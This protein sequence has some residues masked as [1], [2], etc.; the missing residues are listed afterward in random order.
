MD[1][2]LNHCRELSKKVETN[3]S[4]ASELLKQCESLQQE[5]KAMRQYRSAIKDLNSDE[6][7][8][9]RLPHIEFSYIKQLQRDNS[10][11]RMLLEEHQ[12]A[13]EM[14]MQKYRKQV[15]TFMDANNV[16]PNNDRLAEELQFRTDQVYN[17]A[18]VMY[19]AAKV[20]D[21]TLTDMTERVSQL[22]YENRHLRELLEVTTPS[23]APVEHTHLTP[24][25]SS[26]GLKRISIPDGI[27]TGPRGP[28]ESEPSKGPGGSKTVFGHGPGGL[29]GGSPLNVM[30]GSTD[31]PPWLDD[32]RLMRNSMQN[33][34]GK[35]TGGAVVENCVE[36]GRESDSN[37][38]TPRPGS[39][40]P[41]TPLD[42]MD[43]V[44]GRLPSSR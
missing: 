34:P 43:A 8:R 11:L 41:P 40:V 44:E 23:M 21:S 42:L 13:L 28:L 1:R 16:E 36:E 18:A 39:H 7:S 31:H 3:D 10:E 35:A 9:T 22:E 30:R 27:R 19:K 14:I 2:L 25:S 6:Q 29:E 15:S 32:K 12:A 5:L 17:M 26:D 24:P 4:A 20:E 37:C 38:P 33:S